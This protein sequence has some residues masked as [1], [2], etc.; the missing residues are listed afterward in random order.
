MTPIEWIVAGLAVAGGTAIHGGVGFGSMLVA[1]PIL[2]LVDPRLVPGPALGAGLLL[3]ALIFLRERGHVHASG[4]R[5]ILVGALPGAAAGAASVAVLPADGLE[6]V[7]SVLVLLAVGLSVLGRSVRPV[8]A[9]ALGAGF[10]SAFMGTAT[11]IGGPP[12]ALL[13]QREAGPTIRAT[14]NAYFLFATVLSLGSLAGVGQFGPEGIRDALTLWPGVVGGFVL[15][16]VT[17]RYID[18]G[19]ARAGVLTVAAGAAIIVLA[20]AVS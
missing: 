7:F 13:Y 19:R 15:S 17:R 8:P 2:V 3:T 20:R 6:I 16:G 4:I 9:A 10:L 1:A 18:R 11:S 12:A 14:L 5:W